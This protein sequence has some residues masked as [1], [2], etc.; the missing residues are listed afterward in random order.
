MLM[1]RKIESARELYRLRLS[2]DN[3]KNHGAESKKLGLLRDL[4]HPFI[5]M[6]QNAQQNAKHVMATATLR[7]IIISIASS[8]VSAEVRRGRVSHTITPFPHSG[9]S[10]FLCAEY[11]HQTTTCEEEACKSFRRRPR[12]KDRTRR[13]K[14]DEE[15]GEAP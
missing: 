8:F 4:S 7:N 11:E 13:A 12:G 9:N 1:K 2:T 15:I 6:M 3:D 10:D 14:P 5:A